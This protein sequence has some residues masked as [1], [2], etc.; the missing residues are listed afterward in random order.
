[1]ELF[2]APGKQS[3][4]QSTANNIEILEISRKVTEVAHITD[5]M[6]EVL[7]FSIHVKGSLHTG[8]PPIPK[9]F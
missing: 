5:N 4:Y 2:W 1:M 3:W 6:E 9:L 7:E 8:L